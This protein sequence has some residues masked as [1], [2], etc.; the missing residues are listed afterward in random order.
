M[1]GVTL[2]LGAANALNHQDLVVGPYGPDRPLA[3][4]DKSRPSVRA[5]DGELP[6]VLGAGTSPRDTAVAQVQTQKIRVSG[7]VKRTSIA[8]RT[9]SIALRAGSAPDAS[10]P[11]LDGADRDADALGNH[12]VDEALLG[13]LPCPVHCSLRVHEDI[14]SRTADIFE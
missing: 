6:Y 13:Q 8:A 7:L 5:G 10:P 14:I 1:A 4:L 12:A 9:S 11:L 2:H 3:L